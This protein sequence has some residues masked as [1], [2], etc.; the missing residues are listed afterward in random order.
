[1]ILLKFIVVLLTSHFQAH[2]LQLKA[3]HAAG[4]LVTI[5]PYL[6]TYSLQVVLSHFVVDLLI[7]H[8]VL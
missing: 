8:E 4:H 5:I 7:S 2:N 3:L 6:H 1:M